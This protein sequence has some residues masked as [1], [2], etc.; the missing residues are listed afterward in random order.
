MKEFLK[1]IE[2]ILPWLFIMTLAYVFIPWQALNFSGVN[3]VYMR[4][5]VEQ[6]KMFKGCSKWKAEEAIKFLVIP[7]AQGVTMQSGSFD[8]MRLSNCAV[9]DKKNW[10]C[11]ES[12]LFKRQTIDGNFADL[13]FDSQAKQFVP[14]S[15]AEEISR[16]RWILMRLRAWWRGIV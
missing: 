14:I 16:A 1:V 15:T 4:T 6:E 8:P 3:T 12:K 11:E 10:V 9:L 2:F 5:C 13:M 7:E